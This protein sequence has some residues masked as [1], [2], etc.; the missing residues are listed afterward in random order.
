MSEELLKLFVRTKSIPT[1]GAIVALTGV[2][3]EILRRSNDPPTFQFPPE[4]EVALQRFLRAKMVC[5]R[6]L[7]NNT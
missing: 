4:C 6:L 5:E 2:T 7:E 1:A 3:P